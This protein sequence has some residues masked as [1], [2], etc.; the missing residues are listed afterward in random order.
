MNFREPSPFF[1]SY[2]IITVGVCI[3]HALLVW[4]MT[5]SSNNSTL[6]RADILLFSLDY[7]WGETWAMS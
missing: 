7:F 2:L 6:S 1:R 5:F 4:G 3:V